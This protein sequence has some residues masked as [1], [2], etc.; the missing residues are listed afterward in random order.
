MNAHDPDIATSIKALAAAARRQ[1]GSQPTA[2]EINA[3][4][5]QTLSA[6]ERKALQNRL[7]LHPESTRALLDM[8]AFP[9]LEPAPPDLE[10]PSLDWPSM[11]A[12]LKAIDAPEAASSPSTASR[13]L[14]WGLAASILLSA[15]LAAWA[16]SLH[17]R[18]QAFSRPRVAVA[19][20]ELVP[21][22]HIERR[23]TIDHQTVEVPRGA[24]EVLL[25]LTLGDRG[26]FSDYA[27]TIADRPAPGTGII[28]RGAGLTPSYYGTFD[29][30]LPRGFLA[31]GTYWLRLFGAGDEEEPQLLAT[32]AMELRYE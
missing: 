9:E 28:W 13:F 2:D 24:G 19:H 8:A 26:T 4:F 20:S 12:G 31:A 17:A 10:I 18:L 6:A 30:Q 32:Y 1:A 23:S 27:L 16:Y 14:A 21:L 22:H 29:L 11:R 7:A 3:Y 15:G 25:I 5:D